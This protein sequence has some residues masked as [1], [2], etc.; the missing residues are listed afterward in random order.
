MSVLFN[1]LGGEGEVIALIDVG[2]ESALYYS[3]SKLVKLLIWCFWLFLVVSHSR[4]GKFRAGWEGVSEV[5]LVCAHGSCGN[6]RA[7]C[8]PC[9]EGSGSHVQ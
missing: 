6:S 3:S 5:F 1:L 2:E 9:L 4:G 7:P 8:T